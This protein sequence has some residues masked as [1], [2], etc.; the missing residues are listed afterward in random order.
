MDAFGP[1]LGRKSA[2]RYEMATLKHA[3]NGK[4]LP[5]LILKIM[6]GRYAPIPDFYSQELQT[7]V[8]GL[9]D[10]KPQNRP[11]VAEVLSTPFIKSYIREIVAFKSQN[12]GR[13]SDMTRAGVLSPTEDAGTPEA[14]VA[15]GEDEELGTVVIKDRAT[16]GADKD[17]EEDEL[18]N[19]ITDARHPSKSEAS[20]EPSGS[21]VVV[22]TSESKTSL[23]NSPGRGN[24]AGRGNAASPRGA[25]R[26][27]SSGSTDTAANARA[28]VT[29]R[30]GSAASL[31]MSPGGAS[32][33]GA[34]KSKISTPSK[35]GAPTKVD[36]SRYSS[37]RS[38]KRDS[39]RSGIS[40]MPV[41]S[42]ASDGASSSKATKGTGSRY[43]TKSTEGKRKP[44]AN[45]P[46][47]S[48]AAA[49]AFDPEATVVIVPERRGL[50]SPTTP[51]TRKAK[52]SV[53]RRTGSG[54]T[55]AKDS[56]AG[57]GGK[58]GRD[59]QLMNERQ[60][61]RET[62]MQERAKNMEELKSHAQHVKSI[63]DAAKPTLDMGKQKKAKK[64]AGSGGGSGG[65]GGGNFEVAVYSQQ[66]VTVTKHDSPPPELAPEVE[67]EPRQ[68][69]RGSLRE[70]IAAGRKSQKGKG[71]KFNVDIHV[72]ERTQQRLDDG[73]DGEAAVGLDEND[74]LEMTVEKRQV[75]W[76][77][78]SCFCL[79]FI[80]ANAD[81]PLSACLP[82][83][84]LRP[85]SWPL[86]GPRRHERHANGG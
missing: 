86:A 15:E 31:S 4:S 3:F 19:T 44:P 75:R 51:D 82:L 38:P 70:Q 24:T 47:P 62:K 7:L 26:W 8:N 18:E 49:D 58:L 53:P 39:K 32:A 17:A 77:R 56:P 57:R 16:D 45:A 73:G 10:S 34:S 66:G 21:R 55:P 65:G 68:V 41:R 11:T 6:R 83:L 28:A 23:T 14:G 5:A 2:N 52:S 78:S 9:L 85:S 20:R 67:E 61:S 50:M 22:I 1:I 60:K 13:L 48:A 74:P 46:A 81:P 37:D 71:K 84:Q 29:R 59:K 64:P 35:I 43:T 76:P 36:G 72:S 42:S 27:G 30:S 63:R 79:L 25:R 12:G 80:N 54:S 33:R 69:N 40:N